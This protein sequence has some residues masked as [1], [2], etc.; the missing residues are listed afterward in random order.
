VEVIAASNTAPWSLGRTEHSRFATRF[1]VVGKTYDPG[2]FP[3]A[4]TRWVSEDYFSAIGLPLRQ[5]RLLNGSDRAPGSIVIN[6]TLAKQYFPGQDPV[7]KKL[8]LGV[9]SPSPGAIDIVGVVGDVREFG[10]DS[11][12]E[13]T[14]YSLAV[15]PRI[16]VLV[17]T[18]G[19]PAPMVQAI[20][21]AVRSSD[22][23]LPVTKVQLLDHLLEQSMA[24]Q[25]FV[26]GLLT[27]FAGLAAFL[28]ATGI[29]GVAGYAVTRRTREFG[30]RAAI[31]A[32]PASLM[33]MV[34][35]ENLLVTVPGVV[36]GILLA[37]VFARF[38][39]S[40]LY[41]VSTADPLAC[42]GAAI[43][44]LL[45]CVISVLIPARRAAVTDPSSALRDA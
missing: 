11:P 4:Q 18:A 20:V 5:G 39:D 7:G 3:V 9:M 32:R 12:P 1:G 19:D 37:L 8:L 14:L 29:Y 40:M 31:G 23:E 28:A 13:P 25:R 26:L 21:S 45:L 33:G 2:H 36:A 24:R 35:R 27:V 30:I 42:A 15:S 41:K 22:P 38:M 6:E 34:I 43:V 17:K 10:L 44:V 16:A